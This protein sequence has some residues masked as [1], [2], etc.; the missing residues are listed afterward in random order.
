MQNIVEDL[1]G[2]KLYGTADTLPELLSKP[3]TSAT[4]D[5]V[6][7]QL[8]KAEQVDRKARTLSYQLKAARFSHPR[9]LAGFDF[10]ES[11]LQAE[12]LQMLASG[13][14]TGQGHNLI[15]VGG[16]GTGKTH[17]SIATG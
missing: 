17:L 14:F 4:L 7:K 13:E 6:L 3:R 10:S 9:D 8:I 15:F 12:Q 2:L 1:R 11:P 5:N 16:I